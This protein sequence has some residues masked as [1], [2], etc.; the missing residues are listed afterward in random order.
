MQTR[1]QEQSEA[2]YVL[3]LMTWNADYAPAV[4]VIDVRLIVFEP[5]K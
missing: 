3:A 2:S 1:P 4:N 5:L